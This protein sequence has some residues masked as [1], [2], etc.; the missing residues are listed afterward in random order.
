MRDRQATTTDVE[1]VSQG[2]SISL[3]RGVINLLKNVFGNYVF[4]YFSA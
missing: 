2:H 1:S 4:A 3:G